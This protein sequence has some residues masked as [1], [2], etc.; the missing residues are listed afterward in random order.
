[1]FR[2]AGDTAPQRQQNV[3]A[4]YALLLAALATQK[5]VNV[6]GRNR[7]TGAPACEVE[8]VHINQ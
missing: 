7:P 4:V 2:D 6:Y 5:S 3:R 1:M 8:H